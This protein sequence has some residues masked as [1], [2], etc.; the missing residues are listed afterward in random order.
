MPNSAVQVTGI[1]EHDGE[2]LDLI[3]TNLIDD[4]IIQDMNINNINHMHGAYDW[5]W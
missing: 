5:Y 2:H 3:V 4:M 1:T